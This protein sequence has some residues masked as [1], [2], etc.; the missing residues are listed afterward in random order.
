MTDLLREEADCDCLPHQYI[1]M[2]LTDDLIAVY[3]VHM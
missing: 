1:T 2:L 3:I